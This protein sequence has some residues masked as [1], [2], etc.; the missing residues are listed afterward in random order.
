MMITPDWMM[1]KPYDVSSVLGLQSVG[2]EVACNCRADA[3]QGK[4]R[5]PVSTDGENDMAVVEGVVALACYGHGNPMTFI[6]Q[7]DEIKSHRKFYP[8]WSSGCS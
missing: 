3:N 7:R 2:F 4:R 1:N 5:L 6:G 8:R